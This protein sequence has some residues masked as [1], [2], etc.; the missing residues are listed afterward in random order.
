MKFMGKC[1]SKCSLAQN[2]LNSMH[3]APE[4][5]FSLNLWK[6]LRIR[7]LPPGRGPAEQWC[8]CQ[9]HKLVCLP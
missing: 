8:G 7:G 5:I 9:N 6:D 2:S 1:N 3:V 4:C